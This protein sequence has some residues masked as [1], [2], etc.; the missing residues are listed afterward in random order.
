MM[1][2]KGRDDSS[3]VSTGGLGKGVVEDSWET[4]LQISLK[5]TQH[6]NGTPLQYSRLENPMDGGA[7]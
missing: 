3:F 6:C 2:N 4:I 1:G 5:L 7:W